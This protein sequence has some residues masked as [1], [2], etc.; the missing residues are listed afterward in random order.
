MISSESL[1]WLTDTSGHGVQAAAADKKPTAAE[2]KVRPT[3]HSR[4]ALV[5]QAD[6]VGSYRRRP[7]RSPRLLRPRRLLPRYATT[8]FF[9]SAV[10]TPC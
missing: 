4:L 2:T 3:L 9:S 1:K 7:T 8:C 5:L 10:A 6:D